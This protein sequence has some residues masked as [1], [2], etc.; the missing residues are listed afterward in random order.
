MPGSA[1]SHQTAARPRVAGRRPPAVPCQGVHAA[2]SGSPRG[3]VAE[4][5]LSPSPACMSAANG[6]LTSCWDLPRLRVGLVTTAGA[7]RGYGGPGF[8]APCR[9]CVELQRRELRDR[10]FRLSILAAP[11][12]AHD[13]VTSQRENS[14]EMTSLA[15][16]EADAV[17]G[18]YL[19]LSVTFYGAFTPE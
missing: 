6:V 8:P 7:G 17:I 18:A 19:S 3:S 11:W 13:P 9:T 2:L 16:S 15:R 5:S 12:A 14:A 10:S 1:L 4:S